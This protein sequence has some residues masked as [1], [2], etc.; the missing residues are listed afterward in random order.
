[1]LRINHHSGNICSVHTHFFVGAKLK[2]NHFSIL[3]KTIQRSLLLYEVRLWNNET[4]CNWVKM[5][6]TYNFNFFLHVWFHTAAFLLLRWSEQCSRSSPVSRLWSSVAFLFTSGTDLKPAP[7][8]A[9]LEYR[10]KEQSGGSRTGEWSEREVECCDVFLGLKWKKPRV[11][12]SDILIK[13]E[14]IFTQLWCL[15]FFWLQSFRNVFAI[16]SFH[17]DSHQGPGSPKVLS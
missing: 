10:G 13:E 16:V 12:R 5:K 14:T 9:G 1:M 6:K 3:Q 11:S 4:C 15:A 8:S 2:G 17:W 7:L